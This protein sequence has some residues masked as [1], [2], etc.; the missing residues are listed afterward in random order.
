MGFRD[1][2]PSFGR[3]PKWAA[4]RGREHEIER[5][6]KA[7]ATLSLIE[8][9]PGP[10]QLNSGTIRRVYDVDPAPLTGL[11][12]Y[13]LYRV[14]VDVNLLLETMAPSDLGGE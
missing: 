10:G 6:M 7:D 4:S 9:G 8:L 13:R 5:L 12:L 14:G 2:Y 11:D 3:P 1:R